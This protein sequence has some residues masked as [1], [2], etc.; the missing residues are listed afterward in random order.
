MTKY[1]II[2]FGPPG[3]G[4]GTQA[5]LLGHHLDLPVIST[6]ELLRRESEKRSALG[7][8]IRKILAEGG[9]VEDHHVESMLRR[10]LKHRDT[11]RG[12]IFDGFPR[13][14]DQQRFL[15]GLLPKEGKN[16]KLVA[17]DIELSDREAVRRI[18]GRRSCHCGEVYHLL[19]RPPQRSGVCDVCG[20]R[21][22]I[23][24]DDKPAV[25]RDRLQTYHRQA[26][27]LIDRWRKAGRLVKVN[28]DHPIDQVAA[29]VTERIDREF[30]AT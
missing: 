22:Y 8:E 2:F 12:A 9:M 11:K 23:R 17:V 21:L 25:I 5:E 29:A 26:E 28:G 13:D 14:L 7:R 30:L 19:S 20:K 10:R 15:L 1:F 6:G 3:S 24:T 27:P 18:G 4:K 16:A